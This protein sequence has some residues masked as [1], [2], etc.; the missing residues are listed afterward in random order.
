[1]IISA[2]STA[3]I[4][5]DGY[6]SITSCEQL[7]HTYKS[8]TN[9]TSV[10]SLLTRYPACFGYDEESMDDVYVIVKATL[11]RYFPEQRAALLNMVFG[12]SGWT[13]LLLHVLIVEV[14]L[15]YTRDERQRL[16]KVSASR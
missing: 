1:M 7:M 2:I 4:S 15:K 5:P 6:R 12:V 10:G 13:A 16:K 14:Y 3:I 11:H 9:T 8:V